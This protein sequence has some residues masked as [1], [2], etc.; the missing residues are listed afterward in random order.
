MRIAS[1]V[2]HALRLLARSPLFTF[3]AVLSVAAG[4]G[5][6]SAIFS[7]A[8]AVLLRPRPGVADPA[9][10]VDIGRTTR[11]TGLDN[12]GYPLFEAMRE[13]TTLLEGMSA[14]RLAPEVMSLGD[15]RSSERV[16]ASL[17]SGTY[18]EVVGTRPAIGRFFTAEEDATPDALPVVVL[19]HG[20]WSRRFA[21]DEAIA[22]QTIRLN[23]RAYTI[24]GVAEEGFTGTTFL[25]TDFWVPMA[26]E[27]HV[28]AADD[29]LLDRHGPV[30][31]TA[32]GRLKPGAT[33][34]QARDEL[35]AIM[36]RYLE[37]TGQGNRT[38]WGVAVAPS[39]RI[40][41][42]LFGPV[43]GF[44]GMLV[45]L[46]GLVLLIACSN[47]A[48]M[49][50]ARGVERRREFATRMAVGA[51]RARLVRQLMLEGLVLALVAG[52]A[53][54]PV[55]YL[56]VSLLA[57]YQP[58]LPVPIALELRIDPRV[59][60]I[61]L[62]LSSV[63]ALAFSLLPA[64]QSTRIDVSP[65]LRGANASADR[66]RVRLRQG[67]VTAQ[68]TV[69][70][71]LLVVAGLFLR[72]LQ[73]AARADLGFNAAHVDTL[74]IDTSIGSY[75]TDAEGMQAV[76]AIIDRFRRVPGVTDAAASRMVPLIS[77]RLG[78]GRLHAPGYTGPDG[79][80]RV[81]ADWDV[82]S[83]DFF[84]TLQIPVL[85]GRAFSA[86]D[87]A[88]TP[89]VAVVNQ[90]FASRV[91]PGRSAVG[92]TLVQRGMDGAEQVLSIV[93]V[94]RDGK[95]ASITEAPRN[96][97]YVPLAQQFMS[98][99]TFYVRR[100]PEQSRVADLRRAVAAFNPMLP[101]LHTATLEESTS[102]GL[103]PQR[104]AAWIA[105]SVSAIGLFLAATGLYGLMAFWV[106][107][108]TREMAIRLALGAPRESLVRLVLRQA[109]TL[110][111]V[112]AVAGV[113]LAAALAMLLQSF[114][115][116]LRPI[117]PAAFG[118][119]LLLLGA[120]ML[121]ASWLPARRAAAMDPMHSLRAD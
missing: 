24:V 39:T 55:A 61:A 26:M 83:P 32:V 89:R 45:A 59:L 95:Y 102:L 53:S 75:S 9:R 112:G 92:Q 93:G 94:A 117:D 19:S 3:T 4:V 12:F 88:G 110:A 86:A 10:L 96:F 73:E 43:S 91:W 90:R 84:R 18:F 81:E 44:V 41:A 82:V 14:M 21:R 113:A 109:A 30:W 71:L 5:G 78:L 67:L 40:P 15:A 33:P 101:V 13:N 80:D 54:V 49:L 56:L 58:Q 36:R 22:G 50:L 87:R 28:R 47:V 6:T 2:R 118:S 46:T 7:L 99:V 70:L 57:G 76:E 69:A 103:L 74:Q 85:E 35:H 66:R 106:S 111:G 105:A 100:Q 108:R 31:L 107:Q 52:A 38:E 51:S 37:A 79:S 115:A 8:D 72:S 104:L 121:L 60:T 77:G 62:A 116:G 34:A 64:L 23:N 42:S 29:P 119:A 20:F 63:S 17:V 1:D 65:V 25:G 48:G 98:D 114:L 27:Q 11:G 68:V 97:I 16:F 120:V